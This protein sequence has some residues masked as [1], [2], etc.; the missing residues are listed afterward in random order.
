MYNSIYHHSLTVRRATCNSRRQEETQNENQHEI[1]GGLALMAGGTMFA[2]SRVSIG[3]G[4]GVGGGYA[5]DYY[6]APVY[7]QQYAPPC[8]GPGYTWVDGYWT[9]QAAVA[10]GPPAS[11]RALPQQLP[12][13]PALLQFVPRQRSLSE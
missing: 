10:S 1:A 13:C 8:P 11:A 2:Q 5:P 4:V 3:V 6:S 12:R 9:P 7:A